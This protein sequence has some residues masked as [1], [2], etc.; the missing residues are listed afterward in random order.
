M[1]LGEAAQ[2]PMQQSFQQM[3]TLDRQQAVANQQAIDPHQQQAASGPS[4]GARVA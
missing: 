3:K 4:I 1:N 2:K